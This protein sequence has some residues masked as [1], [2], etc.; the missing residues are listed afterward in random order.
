M[1]IDSFSLSRAPI[2]TP[3]V[4]DVVHYPSGASY[5]VGRGGQ[6]ERLSASERE[7]LLSLSHKL[8]VP[9]KPLKG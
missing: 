7:L 3:Q 9:M 8:D 5:R 2:E 4:G 6:W 1:K